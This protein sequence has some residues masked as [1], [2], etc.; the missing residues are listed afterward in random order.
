MLSGAGVCQTRGIAL[1][2]LRGHSKTHGKSTQRWLLNKIIVSIEIVQHHCR[3][4]LLGS[5]IKR[6]SLYMIEKMQKNKS[7]ESAYPRH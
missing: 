2:P 6:K 3:T 5:R 1:D 7:K 4:N